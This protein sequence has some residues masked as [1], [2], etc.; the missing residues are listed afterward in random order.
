MTDEYL[1]EAQERAMEMLQANAVNACRDG[2]QGMAMPALGRC[3]DCD[4]EFSPTDPDHD[5]KRFCDAVCADG[6]QQW[7]TAMKRRYGQSFKPV[8]AGDFVG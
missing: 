2:A 1:I 8:P 6:W 4:E 7:F 5:K 3:Y